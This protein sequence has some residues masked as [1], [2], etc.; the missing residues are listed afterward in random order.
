[1]ARLGFI[2]GGKNHYGNL[3]GNK[4]GG[5]Q[6]AVHTKMRKV[7]SKED[8]KPLGG[9]KKGTRRACFDQEI[10]LENTGKRQGNGKRD[11]GRRITTT[12]EY[13]RE[14]RLHFLWFRKISP[15]YFR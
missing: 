14:E 13:G 8:T 2:R 15:G 3:E 1:L 10:L 7:L 5:V 4:G 6:W 12:T 11:Q 9:L